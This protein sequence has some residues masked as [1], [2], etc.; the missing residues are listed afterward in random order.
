M[1]IPMAMGKVV[2]LAKAMGVTN[3]NQMSGCWEHSFDGWYIACNGHKTPTKC[4]EGP[5]VPPFHVYFACNGWPGGFVSPANG[6]AIGG[7]EDKFIAALSAEIER[8]QGSVKCGQ[9]S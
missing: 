1:R 8:Q 9:S 4:T 7:L 2:E 6:M 3:I 5:E